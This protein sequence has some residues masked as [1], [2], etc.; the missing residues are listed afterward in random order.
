MTTELAHSPARPSWDCRA[1]GRPWPCDPAREQ[2]AL[3]AGGSIALA[4]AAWVY[5]EEFCRDQPAGPT[6]EAFDRFIRW[7]HEAAR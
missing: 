1:C 3:Q 7:T 4:T 5:L 2:L 6:S